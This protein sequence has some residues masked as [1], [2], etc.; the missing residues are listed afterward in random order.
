MVVIAACTVA[1]DG[2]ADWEHA[3]DLVNRALAAHQ[4]ARFREAIDLYDQAL[5]IVRDLRQRGAEAIILNNLGLCHKNLSEYRQAIAL[6][7]QSLEIKRELRDRI[8]E[9]YLGGKTVEPY[10]LHSQEGRF[11]GRRALITTGLWADSD[12][13]IGGPFHNVTFYDE[14]SGRSYMI[15][16]SVHA[17]GDEKLPILRRLRVLARSFVV[18]TVRDGDI[19]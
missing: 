16:C 10:Y 19:L 12:P 2:D 3:V 4:E 8:G 1:A 7:E 13:V 17:A 5:V 18:E 14:T 6:Y 15:D 9:A 11:L